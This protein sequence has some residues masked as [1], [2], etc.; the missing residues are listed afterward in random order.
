MLRGAPEDYG[1]KF[2]AVD[3]SAAF[4]FFFTTAAPDRQAALPGSQ[5]LCS[6]NG[7]HYY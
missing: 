1:E 6:K 7:Y 5:K 2:V 3:G 4:G